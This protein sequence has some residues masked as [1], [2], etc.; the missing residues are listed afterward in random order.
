VI[1]RGYAASRSHN[2]CEYSS[3][4]FEIMVRFMLQAASQSLVLILGSTETG[5]HVHGLCCS[6]KLCGSPFSMLLLT[7]KSKESTVAAISMIT[8]A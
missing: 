3:Q 1:S 6:H 5:V 7:I 4:P 2:F 8:D